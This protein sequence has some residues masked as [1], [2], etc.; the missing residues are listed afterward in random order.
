VELEET[1][2]DDGVPDVSS[3]RDPAIGS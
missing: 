3:K 2:D 1:R